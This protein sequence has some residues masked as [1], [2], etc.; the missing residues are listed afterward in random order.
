LCLGFV[1]GFESLLI[2]ADFLAPFYRVHEV[3]KG[4]L[5]QNLILKNRLLGRTFLFGGLLVGEL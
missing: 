5:F 1:L 3:K 2:I 4:G